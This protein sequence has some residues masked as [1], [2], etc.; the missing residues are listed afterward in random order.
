MKVADPVATVQVGTETFT[1]T[2]RTATLEEK[3]RLWRLMVATMPSY[4]GYRKST[5]RD[6]PVVIAERTG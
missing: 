5:D 4:E 2:A 1:V 6:I 3:P